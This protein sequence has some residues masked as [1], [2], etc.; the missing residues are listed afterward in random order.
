MNLQMF[1]DPDGKLSSIRVLTFMVVLIVMLVWAYIS[2]KAGAMVMIDPGLIGVIGTL[3][4]GK[5]VQ[6]FAEN[7]K[8][9]ES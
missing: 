8:S 2:M 5:T 1:D 9:N 7:R 4:G 6:S 3:V